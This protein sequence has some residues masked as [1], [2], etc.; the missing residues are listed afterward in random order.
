V[1]GIVVLSERLEWYQPVGGL[2]ILA[3]VAV[4][5]GLFSRHRAPG[6]GT[7]PVLDERPSLVASEAGA[8]QDCSAAES[9]APPLRAN[10]GRPKPDQVGVTSEKPPARK[11]STNSP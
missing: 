3:G 10:D 11:A 2:I 8:C 4:S 7:D 6:S 1:V 5:Q 9:A